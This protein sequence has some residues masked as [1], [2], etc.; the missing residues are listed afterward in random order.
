MLDEQRRRQKKLLNPAFSMNHMR[1]MIPL[2]D[3][4]SQRVRAITSNHCIPLYD[5]RFSLKI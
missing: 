1:Q 5:S 2:F 4:L 3:S